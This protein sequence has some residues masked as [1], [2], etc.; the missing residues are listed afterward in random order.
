MTWMPCSRWPIASQCSFMGARSP[1][2]Q[3]TKS[4]RAAR[5]AT[6]ISVTP[7]S[8]HEREA[9][10]RAEDRDLLRREPG[11]VRRLAEC[12][13]R[14]SDH[15]DRPQRHGQVDHGEHTDGLARAARR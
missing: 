13:R 1:P 6:R 15:A 10:R 8:C 3:L 9:A 7:K 14:R 11:A 2:A 4:V 12:E 5:Y